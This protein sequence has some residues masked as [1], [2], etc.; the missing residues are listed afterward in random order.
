MKNIITINIE[1]AKN[2]ILASL[3]ADHTNGKVGAFKTVV[4]LQGGAG[5]GKSE[6][7]VQAS[8]EYAERLGL[9]FVETTDPS[10]KQLGFS[11]IQCSNV[12][13]SDLAIPTPNADKTELNYAFNLELLP[14]KGKG[15]LF[16]DELS[17][18]DADVQ[19]LLMALIR[20]RSVNGYHLPKDWSII[21]AYNRVQDHAGANAVLKTLTD[22]ITNKFNVEVDASSWIKWASANDVH[23]HV[24]AFIKADNR[25]LCTLHDADR[26]DIGSTPRTITM[27]SD[28]YHNIKNGLYKDVGISDKD[29]LS[30]VVGDEVGTA[31]STFLKL[32]K[33]LPSVSEIIKNPDEVRVIEEGEDG[34][35]ALITFGLANKVKSEKD[36]K[37]AL[38]YLGKF[39]QSE[40]ESFFATAL[41]S[42]RPELKETKTFTDLKL[43][44]H[45]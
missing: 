14:R 15:I 20:Q 3:L 45:L 8:K 11:I 6:S 18:G 35:R 40:Y 38:I 13:A 27:M 34:C 24:M 1:L 29:I 9:E 32:V 42:K 33:K 37:N 10:D 16:V 43:V 31:F 41:V 36:F 17:Q 5:V 28:E 39:E 19:K 21:C 7:I 26:N 12:T 2:K 30:S 44:N 25:M 4:G 22:R 23:P